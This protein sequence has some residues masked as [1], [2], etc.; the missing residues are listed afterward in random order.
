MTTASDRAV[1]PNEDRMVQW[2]RECGASPLEDLTRRR[3]WTGS[4]SFQS[5][6]ALIAPA[7]CGWKNMMPTIVCR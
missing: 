1:T 4:R 2:L 5:S 6:A 3:D 7:S